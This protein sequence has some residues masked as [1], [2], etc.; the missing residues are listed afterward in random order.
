MLLVVV[1][2]KTV[3]DSRKLPTL[4]AKLLTRTMMISIIGLLAVSILLPYTLHHRDLE[5]IRYEMEKRAAL[6]RTGLLSTMM[7]TGDPTAIRGAVDSFKE[8]R[9]VKFNI[10]RSEYV[11]KQFGAREGETP[12]DQN[13]RDVLAGRTM[14]YENFSGD[15]FRYIMPYVSEKKCQKCHRDLDG[16]PIPVGSIIGV[17]EFVFDITERRNAAFILICKVMAV[18]LILVAALVFGLYKML[19]ESVLKPMKCITG[20]IARLEKEEFDISCSPFCAVN[21]TQEFDVLMRQLKQMAFILKEKKETREK[22]LEDER[23][24]LEQVRSFALERADKLGIKDENEITEIMNRLSHAIKD[25]EKFEIMTQVCEYVTYEKK[26]LTFSNSVELIIP[27]ALYLTNLVTCKN[28]IKKGAIEL[29]LEEAIANA[30][31]HG[32]LEV[33]SKLKEEDYDKFDAQIAERAKTLPYSDRTVKVSYNY[34][35]EKAVF[36]VTD[37]GSG[38]DWKKAKNRKKDEE[39]LTYGRGITIM[40]AF[41][42]SIEY[43]EKGNEA[44]LTFNTLQ[45]NDCTS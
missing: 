10:F 34:S 23:K 18:I 27:A 17:T 43:N 24:K 39:Y 21:Q 26:E 9:D 37:E 11:L 42:S 32:N 2:N 29:A 20:N 30:M 6:I 36:T 3:D 40:Q 13:V 1:E 45:D 14:K 5:I 8:F 15:T 12:T 35:N 28:I 16:N 4:Q 44:T 22:A 25:A 19:T 7:S 41:A 38:F 31:V 33:S